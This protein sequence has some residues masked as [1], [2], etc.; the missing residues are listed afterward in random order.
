MYMLL[1]NNLM[2]VMVIMNLEYCGDKDYVMKMLW[3]LGIIDD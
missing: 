3:W 1:L 2:I